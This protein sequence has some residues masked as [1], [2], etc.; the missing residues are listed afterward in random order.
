MCISKEVDW[1]G[2][3]ELYLTPFS[4]ELSLGRTKLPFSWESWIFLKKCTLL[5]HVPT[6][7]FFRNLV[8]LQISISGYFY[9][10]LFSPFLVFLR[11]WRC[12]DVYNAGKENTS[13]LLVSENKLI[14]TSETILSLCHNLSIQASEK[15]ISWSRTGCDLN[16]VNKIYLTRALA[17]YVLWKMIFI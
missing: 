5:A 6:T 13:R 4:T 17:A 1:S 11:L 16:H 10:T 7:Y 12:S 8:T 2:N 9:F 15:L 14:V 3:C